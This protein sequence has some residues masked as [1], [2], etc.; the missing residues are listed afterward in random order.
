MRQRHYKEAGW[1]FL[2]LFFMSANSVAARNIEKTRKI[3]K[4]FSVNEDAEVEITNKYGKVHVNTWQ[5]NEVQLT[6]EILVE[7]K[8]EERAQDRLESIEIEIIANP[9]RVSATTNIES[10]KSSSWWGSGWS[11]NNGNHRMEINY[12]LFIPQTNSV[13]I[14]NKYGNV[15][16][17]DLLGNA[18]IAVKY[19]NLDAE[20]LAGPRT[21]IELGYGNGK[22]A[23][24]EEADVEVKYSN[25]EIE[26]CRSL[27]LENKYSDVELG[28]IGILD[29]E[30]KYGQLDIERVHTFEGD[31]RYTDLDIEELL[32]VVD[33]EVAYGS[34][35]NID[36]IHS[37]F[38]SIDI[39]A[40]YINVEL[41]FDENARFKVYADASYGNI[42]WDEEF[43]FEYKDH[44]ESKHGTNESLSA[45]TRD[46]TGEVKVDVD[47][48]NL[49]LRQ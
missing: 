32:K 20:K 31:V 9:E 4:T 28:I 45:T 17:D 46:A 21:T 10:M 11:N 7:D 24:M 33:V 34:T 47:Y 23:L 6:I 37:D 49:K 3:E 15:F 1:F 38:E 44:D 5:K 26:E 22:I 39:E 30:T 13:D 35:F 8:N 48:G 27:D 41:N 18:D 36:Y 43:D 16:I 40:S 42:K 2:I 29:T 14:D 12:T 19:G 25:L